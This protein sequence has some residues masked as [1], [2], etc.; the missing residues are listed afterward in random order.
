V[1]ARSP[2][3]FLMTLVAVG[4]VGCAG[5]GPPAADRAIPE[6]DPPTYAEVARAYNARVTL[7][8]RLWSRTVVRVDYVDKDGR[9]RSE[10]VEGH[11]QFIAPRRFLMTFN[12]LGELYF[13]IGSN[14]DVYWWIQ[15]GEEKMATVGRY[16]AD[17]DR[18]D[19]HVDLPVHPLDLI[20]LLAIR[21]LPE[22]V[23]PPTAWS[24]SG[25][26]RVDLPARWGTR[27][28]LFDPE[29]L[30]PSRVELWDRSGTLAAASDLTR[31]LD[32]IVER[33][34]PGPTPRVAQ[35][36]WVEAP[37]SRVSIKVDL[38]EPETSERRPFDRSFVFERLIDAY[39]VDDIRWIG[40]DAHAGAD[41]G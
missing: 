28:L 32:V 23:A 11:L 2:V 30:E 22:D 21:P 17:D 14:E 6:G 25:L 26:V 40:E 1:I 34:E 29:T 24:E 19:A 38:Y 4:L 9:D 18:P 41:P 27:R 13:I 35:R 3:L 16:D 20:E 31:Y 5:T 7:L 12:K 8:D 39:R 15:L 33:D 10:Q 36:F 37:E